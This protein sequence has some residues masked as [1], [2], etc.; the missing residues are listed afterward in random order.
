ME[1]EMRPRVRDFG[2]VKKSL[3]SMGLRPLGTSRQL[4][5][6]YGNVALYAGRK[7]FLLRIRSEGRRHF[8]TYKAQTGTSGRYEEHEARI[9]GP[10]V[11]ATILERSGFE[12]IMDVAKTRTSY[13]LGGCTVNLDAV[14]GLGRFVELEIIS[15]GNAAG[16]L[17]KAMGRLGI[18]DG[19]EA[20]QGYLSML[21]ALRGSR[22][23]DYINE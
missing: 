4:D 1:N 2:G 3:S 15:R 23:A 12:H 17:R 18:R 13:R 6:Y 5:R 20:G 9:S 21:L 7:G 14:D 19:T 11:L 22:Y 8:L 10:A 16:P